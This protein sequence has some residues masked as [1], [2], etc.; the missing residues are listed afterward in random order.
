MK[1]AKSKKPDHYVL[2]S[3]GLE[4]KVVKFECP[5]YDEILALVPED[6]NYKTFLPTNNYE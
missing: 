5:Y 2:W 4:G 1:F 6:L 3:V